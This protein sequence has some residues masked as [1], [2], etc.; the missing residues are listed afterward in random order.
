MCI[1]DRGFLELVASN[2]PPVR[3]ETRNSLPTGA[4]LASSASGFAALTLASARAAGIGDDR[5][6][7][8]ALARRGS[9]SACRSLWGGFVAWRRGSRAD[10]LDSHGSPI[11]GKEHWDLSMI[12]AVVSSG[13]KPIGSTAAM[14]RT[15]DTSPYYP[16]WLETSEADVDRAIEAI[17]ERDL[18]ALG[19]V[20]EQSTFKMHATMH[21]AVPAVNY[22][23]PGTMACIQAV[24]DLRTRGVTA[25][26]TMD[27]GPN[28]KVLCRSE[29]AAEVARALSQHVERVEILGPGPE[30]VIS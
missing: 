24:F 6:A 25:Y 16:A 10:G 26:L 28:V 1:R 7:L 12:V 2:R 9:G 4:G 15:R 5:T 22:W 8:S 17:H 11:A 3:I 18:D 20:M 29:D 21:T 19:T 27:A 13:P 30:P 14:E 23:L